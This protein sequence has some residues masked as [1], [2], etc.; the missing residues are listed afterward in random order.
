M[1]KTKVKHCKVKNEQAENTGMRPCGVCRKGVGANSIFV[2]FVSMSSLFKRCKGIQGSLKI[3]GFE[4]RKCTVGEYREEVRK[5]V[6][7]ISGGKIECVSKFFYLG[8]TIGSAGGAEGASRA[9]VRS[10]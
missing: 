4:C 9:R 1:N 6:K 8:D 5:E 2:Q 10:A 3:V 7:I